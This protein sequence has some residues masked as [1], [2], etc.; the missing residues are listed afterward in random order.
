[1]R[2]IAGKFKGKT[3]LN[4][5]DKK[6]RPPK[7]IVRQ[8]IFNV[9]EHSKKLNFNLKDCSM[10]DLYSGTGSFGLES[11]SRGAKKVIFVEKNLNTQKILF[12]NIKKLN[13]VSQ[14]KNYDVSVEE[15]L[16]KRNINIK[17]DLIFCDPP[18][19]D[20]N[21]KLI[22]EMIRKGSFLEKNNLII[23][24]RHKKNKEKYP[25]LFKIIEQ[26]NYGNSK[27]IFGM[28]EL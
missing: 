4:T 24:H 8:G 5:S 14:I 28:Y 7:N 26:K 18:F 20:Q 16:K 12:N 10:L 2:I 11:L 17:V 27:I 25:L 3:I 15:F 9:L 21:I 6:T 13:V 1:M 22:L 19:K 23:L